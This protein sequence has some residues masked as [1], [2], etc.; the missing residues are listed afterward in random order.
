MEN[1][2]HLCITGHDYVHGHP[3]LSRDKGWI[4]SRWA[5]PSVVGWERE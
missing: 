4:V 3:E 5:D 2:L 1:A